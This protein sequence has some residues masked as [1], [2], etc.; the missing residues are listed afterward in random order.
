MKGILKKAQLENK[1]LTDSNYC[2][3][4]FRNHIGN[5]CKK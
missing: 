4:E 2:Y 5:F 3:S 1:I